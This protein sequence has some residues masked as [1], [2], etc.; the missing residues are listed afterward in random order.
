MRPNTMRI[1]GIDP[2]LQTTGYA[3][4]ETTSS[5]PR[6]CE[7]GVVR[8]AEDRATTDMA[9]RLKVLYDGVMEVLAE[10]KPNIMCVEQ[11]Y[12][13]YEHPRTAILM[14]HARGCLML[15]GAQHHIDVLSYAATRVKKTITGHGRADKI[16]I[17]NAMKRE[18]NLAKLPEPHDV[19]DALAIALCHYYCTTQSI[20]GGSRNVTFMGVNHAMLGTELS[21][22]DAA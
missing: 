16:Q 7:A 20:V 18:L 12:A 22:E 6:V 15:A 19:S 2:G 8:S 1:L 4:L 17:Q 13:H 3:V 9:P 21:P 14:G 5:G 10:W 11:L